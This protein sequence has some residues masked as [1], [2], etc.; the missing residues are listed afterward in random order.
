VQAAVGGFVREAVKRDPVRLR[1]YLDRQVPGLR[2]TVLRHV[3][4][5]LPEAE[6]QHYRRQG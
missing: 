6:R 2:A 1:A 4:R 5:N 3:I